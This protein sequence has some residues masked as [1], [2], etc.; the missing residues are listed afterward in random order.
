MLFQTLLQPIFN[1]EAPKD[2]LEHIQSRIDEANAAAPQ[3]EEEETKRQAY[4]ENLKNTDPKKY[5]K[6]SRDAI[7]QVKGGG[8][9]AQ[10]QR[11]SLA[12]FKKRDPQAYEDYCI[13]LLEP[14]NYELPTVIFLV[15]VYTYANPKL[16][17]KMM[18]GDGREVQQGEIVFDYR[19]KKWF[20][21]AEPVSAELDFQKKTGI[22]TE[23]QIAK[24]SPE[25]REF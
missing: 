25:S 10:Q 18:W 1:P 14:R 12:A 20:L 3:L 13:G 17:H 21:P 11:E 9:L 5:E 4:W 2:K 8:Q 7:H 15:P 6:E 23:A 19:L 24:M 22:P 16:P